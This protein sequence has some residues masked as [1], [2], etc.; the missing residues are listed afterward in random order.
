MSEKTNN[1]INIK[2]YKNPCRR[3]KKIP[4]GMGKSYAINLCNVHNNFRI[5]C[6][7]FCKCIDKL[8]CV[9]YDLIVN[10]AVRANAHGK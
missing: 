3:A 4:V 6:E 8:L 5:F 7:C 2:K 10:N 1:Y 9:C